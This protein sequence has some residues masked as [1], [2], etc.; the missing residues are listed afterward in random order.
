VRCSAISKSSG[1]RCRAAA[2]QG[3]ETCI[4][5]VPGKAAAYGR[6][7]ARRQSTRLR[8]I[9]T[10]Q[11]VEDFKKLIAITATEVRCGALQPRV[12]AAL[13]ALAGAF[14]R[15]VDGGDV[16]ERLRRLEAIAAATRS[17]RSHR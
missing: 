15:C 4:L 10:P 16:Q 17:G 8:R 12:A 7:R 3:G 6:L 5:H 9:A 11:T 14:L 2:V 13:A 1:A